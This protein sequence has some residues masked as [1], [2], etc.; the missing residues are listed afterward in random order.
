L[1]CTPFKALYGVDPSPGLLPSLKPSEH[2]DVTDLLKERQ[3]FIEL[4]KEQLAKAQKRMK[5]QA[6]CNRIERQFQM[7]ENVLLKL[8]P[9]AQSF[10][11]NRPFPKLAYKYFG[12]Y[13]VLEKMV[14][15][16]ISYSFQKGARFTL[17]SMFLSSRLLLLIILQVHIVLPHIAQLDVSDVALESIL[18]RH[19]V[20][21]GN[22]AITQILAKW[23]GLPDE[24]STWEDYHVLQQRF[25]VVAAWGQIASQDGGS[26][27]T[28]TT[29][30]LTT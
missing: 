15:S 7:G 13:E 6:D 8:Q 10:M 30:A 20:K 19:L 21:K 11:V 9:Y 5:M 16:H 24:S 29:A 12:P 18:D 1:N 22:E 27:T 4:L 14:L 17:H 25:L 3:C 2:Q 28:D 26:A 23:I